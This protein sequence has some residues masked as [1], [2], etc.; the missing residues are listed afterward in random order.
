[1]GGY[2]PTNHT[3]RGPF[4]F[5]SLLFFRSTPQV[6]NRSSATAAWVDVPRLPGK[7]VGWQFSTPEDTIFLQLRMDDSCSYCSTVP[8]KM[9]TNHELCQVP[10]VPRT[11]VLKVHAHNT[12]TRLWLTASPLNT[13]KINDIRKNI[14]LHH[15]KKLISVFLLLLYRHVRFGDR[16]PSTPPPQ[17]LPVLDSTSL[18]PQG[19]W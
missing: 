11:H 12:Y 5:C 18:H 17:L 9:K 10:Q 6:P 4:R 13:L 3:Q 8:E 14:I 16:S 2:S 19:V 7:P 1:M 15:W